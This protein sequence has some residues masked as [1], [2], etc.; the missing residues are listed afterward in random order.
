MDRWTMGPSQLNRGPLHYARLHCFVAEAPPCLMLGLL[1]LLLVLAAGRNQSRN[2]SGVA[3]RGGIGC[4]EL[5]VWLGTEK[6]YSNDKRQAL[7]EMT[8]D[9]DCAALPAPVLRLPAVR[10]DD[11]RKTFARSSARCP[12]HDREAVVLLC[13]FSINNNYSHFLHALLRLFCALVDGGFVVWTD[14][15][16]TRPAPIVLWLDNNFK[17]TESKLAWIRAVIGTEG[18]LRRLGEGGCVSADSLVYGSGCARLLPPEKWFGYPGCRAESVASAFRD[19][20]GREV[21]G[22][23]ADGVAANASSLLV[24]F[25]VREAGAETGRRAISNLQAVQALLRRRRRIDYRVGNVSFE[26]LDVRETLAAMRRLD[27]FVSVHGAGLTNMLFMRP[28]AAVVE[29]IPWP[30]C[31][32]RSPDYF[33]G[34]GGYYHGSALALGLSYF[35]LCLS[36]ADVSWHGSPPKLKAGARCSWRQLHAVESVALDPHLLRSVL[37]AVERELVARGVLSLRSPSVDL[38]PRVNG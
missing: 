1:S 32:C 4:D 36:A 38:N 33:Y 21:L 16:W 3:V 28:G 19:Y 22:P 23:A 35:P 6:H 14:G 20:I 2:F 11:T 10:F 34:A 15:A 7:F 8:R 26:R 31:H 37:R 24:T 12:T 17:L 29:A 13:N 30:L 5:L 25:N 18:V 9:L 27:V